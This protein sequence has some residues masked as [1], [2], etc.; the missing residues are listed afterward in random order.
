MLTWLALS[1]SPIANSAGSGFFPAGV[2]ETSLCLD[3]SLAGE[4]SAACGRRLGGGFVVC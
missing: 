1:S 4:P 3:D 2:A